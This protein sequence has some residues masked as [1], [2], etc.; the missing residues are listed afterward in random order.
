MDTLGGGNDK[1]NHT[2][3]I[4]S[5]NNHFG[6]KDG[7]SPTHARNKSIDVKPVQD[8][9]QFQTAKR[10]GSTATGDRQHNTIVV[11]SS[12]PSKMSHING[13]ITTDYSYN[14]GPTSQYKNSVA[15]KNATKF[16][17]LKFHHTALDFNKTQ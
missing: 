4:Q 8:H 10:A 15:P 12:N 14:I 16:S 5:V 2:S 13:G 7:K 1:K 11:A 9:Y 6:P 3:V 17:D